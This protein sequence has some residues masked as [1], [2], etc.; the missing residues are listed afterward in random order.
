MK[1]I[2][3]QKDKNDTE[4]ILKF[5]STL[6]ENMKDLDPEFSDIVDKYFYELI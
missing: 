5:T 6:K 3:K 2:K 1:N 4:I